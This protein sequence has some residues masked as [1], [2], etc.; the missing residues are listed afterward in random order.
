MK[1]ST[2]VGVEIHCELRT[3]TKMFSSAPVS[4]HKVPNSMVNEID[5]ALPGTLPSVNK[6]AVEYAL[7]ACMALDMEID[8]VVRFDRK[9]Y[10]YPDLPKG[11]QTTQQFHPVGKNG[12]VFLQIDGIKK[13]IRIERLHMEEDTAQMFHK[14]D[15][16]YIDYN[17][18]G[19][20][21]IEIVSAPDMSSGNEAAG[22]VEI[23][24]N[25]LYY[26]GVSD[27]KMEEGSL[28][29]DINV[30]VRPWDS[31]KLGVKTEIK[32]LNSI[33]N[34]RKAVDY[35]VS[36]Q[37]EILDAGKEVEPVTLRFEETSGK[38]V[39]MRRKEESVD[40]RYFPEPNIPAIE[41]DPEWIGLIRA[42]LPELPEQ[43][44]VRYLREYGLSEYEAGVLVQDKELSDYFD[45]VCAHT[46]SYK[47]ASKY[48]LTGVLGYMNAGKIRPEDLKMNPADFALLCDAVTDKTVYSSQAKSIL[49]K[50]LEG[51]DA[52]NLIQSANKGKV[53]DIGELA[54]AVKQVI[55]ENPEAVKD[56]KSGKDRALGYLTGKMM[57]KTG[58]MA[59]P[60]VISR[61][62]KEEIDKSE[63]EW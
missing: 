11:Y 12:H 9:N 57:K 49:T 52:K 63:R 22:Y 7:A 20:P 62:I 51:A 44:R 34:I 30:S 8:P 47:T 10:Y 31:E 53:S 37:I 38:T 18:A 54:K 60:A 16:T 2:T 33:S 5:L 13:E 48:L 46:K 58:G 61:L 28:R 6:K 21:L 1:Y 23:L 50:I 26:L 43:R 25:T 3:E 32:N 27:A 45:K 17:R 35:E 59:D 15:H 4:F 41:L 56:Y 39:F 24:R 36:R 40:Y 42:N 55:G 14:G 19:I 29:C